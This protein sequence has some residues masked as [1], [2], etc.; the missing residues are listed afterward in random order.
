MPPK[1]FQGLCETFADHGPFQ[2][3]DRDRMGLGNVG[4]TLEYICASLGR[5]FFVGVTVKDLL[6]E[7]LLQTVQLCDDA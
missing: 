1:R 7:A 3:L 6:C 2:Y 5:C 4:Y